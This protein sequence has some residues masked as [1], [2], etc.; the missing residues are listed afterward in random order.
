[1]CDTH[2]EW[3]LARS[4]AV[5]NYDGHSKTGSDNV[6]NWIKTGLIWIGVKIWKKRPKMINR[7]SN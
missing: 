6:G 2:T 5:E 7:V 3:S 4:G 1:M